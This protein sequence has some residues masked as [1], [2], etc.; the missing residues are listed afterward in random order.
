MLDIM[1]QTCKTAVPYR[2][3]PQEMSVAVVLLT[4]DHCASLHKAITRP[5]ALCSILHVDSQLSPDLHDRLG[6]LYV[7]VCCMMRD[8]LKK[9]L[10]HRELLDSASTLRVIVKEVLGHWGPEV[11]QTAT[12]GLRERDGGYP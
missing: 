6:M 4:C 1:P 5:S 2:A 3:C 7:L 12:D 10:K 9:A 8:K 11:A